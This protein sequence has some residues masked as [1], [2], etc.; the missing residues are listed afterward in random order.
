MQYSEREWS[1][2]KIV[3]AGQVPT[4]PRSPAQFTGQA[5]NEL[6]HEPGDAGGMR[7]NL[8]L[9][10]PGARCWWHRHSQGQTIYV[11]AGR[12]RIKAE[13]E[14]GEEIRA[15]DTIIVDPHTWH[16]HGAAPDSFVLH[17]TV[18]PGNEASTE[19]RG[20]EVSDEEYAAFD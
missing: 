17:L 12:G 9:F 6:I 8:V 19:W 4:T 15:G 16:W 5:W 18:N 3:R 10:E 14:P 13:G 2:V 20:R 1:I 7:V 11:T